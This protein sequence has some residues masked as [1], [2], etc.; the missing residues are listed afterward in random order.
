MK[1]GSYLP[2]DDNQHM[3]CLDITREK[4]EI[5]LSSCRLNGHQEEET[6]IMLWKERLPHQNSNL[7]QSQ[8]RKERKPEKR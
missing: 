3:F 8:N 6:D 1:Q 5:L 2:Y 4:R 7:P